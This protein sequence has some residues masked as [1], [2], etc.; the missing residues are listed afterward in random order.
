[1]SPGLGGGRCSSE[2]PPPDPPSVSS[3]VSFRGRVATGL[4][5]AVELWG[6]LPSSGDSV[7]LTSFSVRT[8]VGTLAGVGCSGCSGGGLRYLGTARSD[9]AHRSC[10]CSSTC[11]VTR[12]PF[13]WPRYGR[14]WV[15]FPVCVELLLPGMI[16]RLP[17]R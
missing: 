17:V 16:G 7:N 5:F 3:T 1:M 2:G 4:A 11:G 15:R 6:L 10:A 8:L 12:C 14:C 9:S 13:V